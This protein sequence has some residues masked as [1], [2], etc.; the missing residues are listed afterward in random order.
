MTIPVHSRQAALESAA[1]GLR[2]FMTVQGRPP[3]RVA[4]ERGDQ[5][6]NAAAPAEPVTSALQPR[7]P[8]AAAA[9]P[10]ARPGLG[11][12]L[13]PWALSLA[14]LL[15]VAALSWLGTLSSSAPPPPTPILASLIV[16]PAPPEVEAP[17][18]P[19]PPKRQPPPQPPKPQSPLPVLSAPEPAA[20]PVAVAPPPAEPL[21]VPAVLPPPAPVVEKVAAVP[22]A[23][24][25]PPAPPAP[26]PEAVT[27]PRF[28]ADYLDNP[29]PVYPTLSR[30]L[31]EEGR[32]LLRVYVLADGSAGQ[33]EI[34]QSSGFDRLDRAA[35]E[36]VARWRFVPARAGGEPVAAWVL[37][38]IH[39]SLRS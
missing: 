2:L 39:F 22:A 6:L 20:S 25:A 27:P 5:G 37:V 1:S 12:R 28:D 31:G 30:R 11:Q 36:A 24:P 23:P 17:P 26:R 16:P 7:V 33:V 29:A 14:A 15:H 32:V 9:L 13:D 38:P 21:P 8:R 35:R 4:A 19:L 10:Q 18:Q 3:G 34:R